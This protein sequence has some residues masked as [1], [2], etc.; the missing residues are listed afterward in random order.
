LPGAAW[1]LDHAWMPADCPPTGGG[2]VFEIRL[3]GP[4]RAFTRRSEI[5][6]AY[7]L[8]RGGG[9]CEI[10]TRQATGP[11]GIFKPELAQL[12]HTSA[13]PGRSSRVC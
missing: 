4:L 12:V 10:R 1:Q 7:C 6:Q 9:G 8:V 13:D 3:L 2:R 11:I 5:A